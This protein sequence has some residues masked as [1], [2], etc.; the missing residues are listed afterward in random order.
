MYKLLLL[1]IIISSNLFASDYLVTSQDEVVRDNYK[2]TADSF[3]EYSR[4]LVIH[5]KNDENA[6]DKID[7]EKI[8]LN[9]ISHNLVKTSKITKN[10]NIESIIQMVSSTKL[11]DTIVMLN[12]FENLSMGSKDNIAVTNWIAAQFESLGIVP[13]IDCFST[14]NCNVIGGEIEPYK[15][16]IIV[17]A[18]FDTVGKKFAGADDNASGTAGL[19]E[20]ARILSQIK[21]NPNIVYIAANGEEKG[22]LGSNAFVRKYKAQLANVSFVINMDMIAYNRSGILDLET[23]Q[24]FINIVEKFG[25]VSI[26][27]T[28]LIPR[29]ISPAWGSDHVPFLKNKVPS[30]L[31]IEDWDNH[32]P[33]YHQSCDKINLLDFDFMKQIVQTNIAYIL[34]Q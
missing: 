2:K 4:T 1:F 7:L 11:E 32:N 27:Y 24:E 29:V 22:L 8:D 14:S 16:N 33:C 20:M 26:A 19:L 13:T 28:N 15:N 10:E 18:H 5:L 21:T 23:S 31:T 3:F 17:I 34:H 30:V 9:E 6:K 25:E 12:T